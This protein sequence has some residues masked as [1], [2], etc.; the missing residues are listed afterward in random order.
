R[1]VQFLRVAAGVVDVV[2]GVE[3]TAVPLD[4]G[5]D[6]VAAAGGV[7]AALVQPVSG[8]IVVVH[9]DGENGVV[10][11]GGLAVGGGPRAGADAAGLEV[12][13]EVTR[14]VGQLVLD[15]VHIGVLDALGLIVLAVVLGVVLVVGRVGV[16]GDVL[17]VVE[18]AVDD[19][20]ARRVG[21]L[22]ERGGEGQNARER[23]SGRAGSR[24]RGAP[25]GEPR[26]WSWA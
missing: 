23:A 14:V 18:F 11:A 16:G 25:G 22:R 5:V 8:L 9:V 21:R 2:A 3:P 13:V 26:A 12:G 10:A 6:I 24:G 17:P 20:G 15:E 7:E 4:L 19:D 1:L